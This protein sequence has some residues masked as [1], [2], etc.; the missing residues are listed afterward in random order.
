MFL[1]TKTVWFNIQTEEQYSLRQAIM[2]RQYFLLNKSN[3]K[4]SKRKRSRFSQIQLFPVTLLGARHKRFSVLARKTRP[5]P[6]V[7]VEEIS[8]RRQLQ[9]TVT[10]HYD[11]SKHG[12]LLEHKEVCSVQHNTL[13]RMAYFQFRESQINMQKCI[14]VLMIY[15][16]INEFS[17]QFWTK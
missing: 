17:T 12:V 7:L 4:Q 3:G 5:K 13:R 6:L 11:R 2:Y 16:V 9:C 1:L 15:Y 8:T 10:N 14:S